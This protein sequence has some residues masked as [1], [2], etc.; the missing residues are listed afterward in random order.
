M[1]VIQLIID[2][3]GLPVAL[4]A[5][6]PFIWPILSGL[7]NIMFWFKSPEDWVAYAEKNPRMA[8]LMRVTRAWGM[9]PIK[10]LKSLKS[11]VDTKAEET[12]KSKSEPPKTDPPQDP[13]SNA[14]GGN[15][16]QPAA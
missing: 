10:G 4:L 13:P 8:A 6:I 2:R 12:R 5:S 11:F 7:M 16:A 3:Y 14:A 9:D 15:A 1:E